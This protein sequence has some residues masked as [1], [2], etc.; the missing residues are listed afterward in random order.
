MT[1]QSA[2]VSP[3]PVSAHRYDIDLAAIAGGAHRAPCS[4]PV[5]C[6]RCRRLRAA[7]ALDRGVADA[8]AIRWIAARWVELLREPDGALHVAF[9]VQACDAYGEE[10]ALEDEMATQWCLEGCL[11][12]V[13]DEHY[14]LHIDDY[15]LI[16]IEQALD[17]ADLDSHPEPE[18]VDGLAG[19]AFA[20][21]R[22]YDSIQAAGG[23]GRFDACKSAS[24]VN[25]VIDDVLAYAAA[26]A[27]DC[28]PSWRRGDVGA[29]AP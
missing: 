7:V 28:E 16:D 2:V 5:A 21:R 6:D 8:E 19:N 17:C 25:A 11:T 9:G 20:L 1:A 18:W 4:D 12:K 13:G 10:V 29:E 26:A 24:E 15:G 14:S 22:L 3:R 23:P 27:H